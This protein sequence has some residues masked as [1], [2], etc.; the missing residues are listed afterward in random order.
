MHPCFCQRCSDL[1]L[2]GTYIAKQ[3]ALWPRC[4]LS[5]FKHDVADV[6]N[7]YSGKDRFLDE[8][9]LYSALRILRDCG[10]YSRPIFKFREEL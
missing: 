1:L 2:S 7:F 3:V 6:L 8:R 5:T 4:A 10:P 9:V